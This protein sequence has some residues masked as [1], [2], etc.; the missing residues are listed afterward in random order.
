MGRKKIFVMLWASHVPILNRIKDDLNVE[1]DIATDGG[2]DSQSDVEMI[3]D[4]M[5]SADATILYRHNTDF[6]DRVDEAMA[7]YRSECKIISL[8]NDPSMW[9]LTTVDHA[10]AVQC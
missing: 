3:V 7:K 1:L 2:L 4:R 6:M 8:A 10:D 5:R 9:G